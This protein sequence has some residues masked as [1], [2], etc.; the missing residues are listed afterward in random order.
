MAGVVRRAMLA[1]PFARRG[2]EAV[3]AWRAAP[4]G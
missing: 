3:R 1:T 4:V 2:V